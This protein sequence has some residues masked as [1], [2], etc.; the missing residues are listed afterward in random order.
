MK[1]SI[2]W[3][4]L[5][6]FGLFSHAGT[7]ILE[8][9]YNGQVF[10]IQNPY[11]GD[12]AGFCTQ[13]VEVNGKE[14]P[15]ENASSFSIDL[16]AMHFKAG[17]TI[18]IRITHRDDC[19]PKLLNPEITHKNYF[20]LV[21]FKTD[22]DS[23]LTWKVIEKEEKCIYIIEQYRWN[24]WIKLDS[25]ENK[26]GK[27]TVSYEYNFTKYIHSGEN[28]FRVKTID[29]FNSP[30]YTKP[31]KLTIKSYVE[32][33]LTGCQGTEQKFTKPTL[34]EV[35]NEKGWVVKSGF[36]ASIPMSDLPKGIY[37]LNYDNKTTEFI[38]K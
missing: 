10:I 7:I 24:K 20:D 17:D 28:Y 5:M 2:G 15:F 12:S 4:V 9:R 11:A 21:S 14:I 22:H 33:F 8:G 35:F 31:V 18:S 1:N 29:P 23:L 32:P 34:Y 26:Q 27:D 36:G 6:C 19:K 13:K 38:K 25:I 30:H 3:C 16:T 37:Y